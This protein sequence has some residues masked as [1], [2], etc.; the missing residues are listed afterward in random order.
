[1]IRFGKWEEILR[2]PEPADY[3][4]V[5]RAVHHYARGIAL[6][7]LGRTDEARA[8]MARFEQAWR[9]VETKPPS[10]CFCATGKG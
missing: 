9:R 4:L 8:E 10:S 3:R 1:M 7:V 2:E 6:S 5:T